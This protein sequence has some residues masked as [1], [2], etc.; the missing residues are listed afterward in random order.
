[1]NFIAR[2]TLFSLILNAYMFNFHRFDRHSPDA[3][4]DKM[5]DHF[6][7]LDVDINGC[8]LSSVMKED[9]HNIEDLDK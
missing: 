1:M 2:F 7:T 6:E 4:Y 8:A 9:M 5:V 3:E